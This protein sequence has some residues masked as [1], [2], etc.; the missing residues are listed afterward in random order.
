M[1][2]GSRS[3]CSGVSC[4][5]DDEVVLL[6]AAAGWLATDLLVSEKEGRQGGRRQGRKER[7]G[8]E[9]STVSFLFVFR[10]VPGVPVLSCPS[11]HGENWVYYTTYQYN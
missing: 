5:G 8:G 2:R 4:R 11:V 6:L 9:R 7:R 3:C 1:H 10:V